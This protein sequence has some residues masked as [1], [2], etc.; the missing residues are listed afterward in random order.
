MKV[1]TCPVASAPIIS[2]REPRVERKFEGIE[3]VLNHLVVS[4]DISVYSIMSRLE[5]SDATD[6]KTG[7]VR[8]LPETVSYQVNK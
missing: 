2:V 6:M 7:E 3:N 5:E 8:T 1:I 4:R